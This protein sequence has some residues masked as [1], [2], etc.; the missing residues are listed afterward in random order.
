LEDVM[1]TV[2]IVITALG[3]VVT[4]RAF[5]GMTRQLAARLQTLGSGELVRVNIMMR[6][7]YDPEV[8]VSMTR[9]LSRAERRAVV[10]G[11]L[12]RFARDTQAGVLDLLA[13]AERA[14]RA[15][16]V[17]V[18]WLVNGI[19]AWVDADTARRLAARRD[20][21]SV[22]WDE[23]VPLDQVL[24]SEVAAAEAS[25]DEI[26]WGVAKVRAPDVWTMGYRGGGVTVAVFDTGCN[27]NH[28]DL[29]DHMWEG[30]PSFP[31]HG[32]NFA[33]NNEETMDYDGHGT[34]VCGIVASDGTAGTQAGVAP[35]ATI[36]ICKV[37]GVESTVW[38]AWQWAVGQGA[39]LGTLSFGWRVYTNPDYATWRYAS[40]IQLSA[41]FIQFKSAGNYRSSVS[42]TDPLPWNVS[43]PGNCPPPWL[44]PDQKLKGGLASMMAVGATTQDDV[45]A[46]F[47]S[48]GPSS[49]ETIDPWR[50]YPYENGAQMGLLKP[51]VAAPGYQIKS[52]RH[53]DNSGY[54]DMSGTSMAAPY[55]AGC[56]ALL[57]DIDES[58]TP[59]NLSEIMQTTALDLGPPGK[60]NDYGAGRLDVYEA[61]LKLLTPVELRYFLAAGRAEGILLSWAP[62]EGRLAGVFNVYRESPGKSLAKINRAP[63]SGRPPFRFFDR[64]VEGGITYRYWLEY[65]PHA[66]ASRT[67]GPAE[68]RAGVKA[69]PFAFA[70]P[71]PN[72][73]SGSVTFAFSLPSDDPGAELTVFDLAGRRVATVARGARAGENVVT[74]PVVDGA[75]RPLPPG[76]YVCRFASSAGSAARR[77]AVAR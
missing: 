77:L 45:Y 9:G 19:N 24:E 72:P 70:Q 75:G 71:R 28:L 66:G 56:A 8:M 48:L 68:A 29:R 51:D 47:S 6:E 42:T 11:E 31:K 49:W 65:V 1:R 25:R 54:R 12:G 64:D 41:G 16:A 67:F 5:D 33:E 4:A 20:V 35:D 34:H 2:L 13:G 53:N 27:Y 59:E 50:D 17:R 36:M 18:M 52:C 62:G 46:Y 3:A 76:V 37:S 55:G 23:E 10:V 57:L 73:A 44:H 22:D 32:W 58:L 43:A 15:R 40:E 38:E 61:A 69:A 30:G 26:A 21:R 74:W 60:D 14:G 39:D 63:V 7:R